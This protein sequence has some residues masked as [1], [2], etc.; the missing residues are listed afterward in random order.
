MLCLRLTPVLLLALLMGGPAK[1]YAQSEDSS[2]SGGSPSGSREVN[3]SAN[4]SAGA[5]RARSVDLSDDGNSSGSARVGFGLTWTIR[6]D[7]SNLF[8]NLSPYYN[9]VFVDQSFSSYGISGGLGYS[10]KTTARRTWNLNSRLAAAPDQDIP[11]PRISEDIQDPGV[12]FLV[13]RNGFIYLALEG[14][15]DHA[16]SS[17]SGFGV[18]GRLD[19]RRYDVYSV[20]SPDEDAVTQLV[21]QRSAGVGAD[22]RYNSSERNSWT[23][24]SSMSVYGL[25]DDP[26]DP[27]QGEETRLQVDVTGSFGRDL[28][29]RSQL[30]IGSGLSAIDTGPGDAESV[31]TL[32]VGWNWNGQ[33]IATRLS[34]DR[35]Q[36]I[37]PGS[38]TSVDRT[39][40]AGNMQWTG[41]KQSVGFL[42]GYGLSRNAGADRESESTTS[43]NASL[44][45]SR[46]FNSLAL[47]VSLFS[48]RQNSDTTFGTDLVSSGGTFGL[49]WRLT[50]GRG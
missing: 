36:G 29:E 7:A 3:F 12:R 21:D 17:R 19:T 46:S 26:G 38:S 40:V 10:R 2:G 45:Y 31:P 4:L 47:F 14:G 27:E 25:G 6:S 35:N 41:R 23:V 49:S 32:K 16:L 33:H 34:L 37:F 1:V 15:F 30:T 20:A 11:N 24:G 50:G 48:Y 28:T 9:K 13:P 8:A 22:W 5:G 18:T 43:Q 44:V 42:V 39:L